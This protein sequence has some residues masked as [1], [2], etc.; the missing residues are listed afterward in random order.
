MST[1]LDPTI[2]DLPL[3]ERPE[4]YLRW[5][6]PVLLGLAAARGVP[7]TGFEE[8]FDATLAAGCFMHWEGPGRSSPDRRHRAT[9][10]YDID[11]NGDA[12]LRL[13][14][15]DRA[16]NRVAEAWGLQATHKL[17]IS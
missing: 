17:S 8:A 7:A 14:I 16:Q 12:W 1:W 6:Q 5:F 9:P 4:A 3:S 2:L 10:Y 15:T 13:T 11:A